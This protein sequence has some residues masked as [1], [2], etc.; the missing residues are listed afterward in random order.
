MYSYYTVSVLN[1]YVQNMHASSV[2][3]VLKIIR[4]KPHESNERWSLKK[5]SVNDKKEKY[6]KCFITDFQYK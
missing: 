3:F 1:I 4:L 2:N 5:S 6:A